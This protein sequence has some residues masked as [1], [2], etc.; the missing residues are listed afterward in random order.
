L[1]AVHLKVLAKQPV[2]TSDSSNNAKTSP[3]EN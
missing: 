3:C 1:D 2:T